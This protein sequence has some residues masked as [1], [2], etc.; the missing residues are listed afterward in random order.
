M[1]SF[2]YIEFDSTYRDRNCYPCPGEFTTHVSCA[3]QDYNGHTARDYVSGEYPSKSWYQVPYAGA[4]PRNFVNVDLTGTDGERLFNEEAMKISRNINGK[5]YSSLWPVEWMEGTRGT[6][7]SSSS[8]SAT[9]PGTGVAGAAFEAPCESTN[10]SDAVIRNQNILMP[11]NF[12]GG[13]SSA[14]Q[15]GPTAIKQGIVNNYFSG[16]TLI[17]F[18]RN[19]VQDMGDGVG[20]SV[21]LGSLGFPYYYQTV[22]FGA[23]TTPLV[24]GRIL[25]QG[26]SVGYVACVL[27]GTHAVVRLGGADPISSKS[28]PPFPAPD[29]FEPGI[30]DDYSNIVS[31][32][33][34]STSYYY[35]GFVETSV[36]T[37]YDA[38]TG[39][40]LLERPFLS[41]GNNAFKPGIGDA[42]HSTDCYLVDFNTDPTGYWGEI[43][44][45]APRL[46]F[47]TGRNVLNYYS[48]VYLQ[49]LTIGQS[50]SA[51]FSIPQAAVTRYNSANRVLY[52]ANPGFQV[53][54]PS[55]RGIPVMSVYTVVFLR[56]PI[57]ANMPAG[58]TV[59]WTGFP[60][61]HLH[62]IAVAAPKGAM[63]IV[64]QGSEDPCNPISSETSLLNIRSGTTADFI[65]TPP[66]VDSEAYDHWTQVTKSAE[67][68]GDPLE[69]GLETVR[70]PTQP[71]VSMAGFVGSYTIA[72]RGKKPLPLDKSIIPYAPFIGD[73]SPLT[74]SFMIRHSGIYELE[75][76]DAGRGYSTTSRGRPLM[77]LLS[78]PDEFEP[79]YKGMG[80][81]P[82]SF[83]KG[84]NKVYTFLNICFVDVIAVTSTGGLL[85]L[86]INTPGSGYRQ[87]SIVTIVDGEGGTFPDEVPLSS[88]GYK[89][90]DG[91]WK[92]SISDS[93]DPVSA[94]GKGNGCAGTARITATYQSIGVFGGSASQSVA[95]VPNMGDSVYIPTYGWGLPK[96]QR[97]IYNSAPDFGHFKIQFSSHE[98]SRNPGYLVTKSSL[99]RTIQNCKGDST[100]YP[101]TGWRVISQA[102][103]STNSQCLISENLKRNQYAAPGCFLSGKWLYPPTPSLQG[104]NE[105]LWMGIERGYDMGSFQGAYACS[106]SDYVANK[107]AWSNPSSFSRD[108]S[109]CLPLAGQFVDHRL[110]PPILL[111]VSCL[112]T[113]NDLEILTFTM[114]SDVPLNYTGSTV[115]QN[116]M[117]CYEVTLVSLILP[118]IPLDTTI[119]GLIAFYPYVYVELSNVSAPS[120]GNK[121]VLYSNNPHAVRA[122]FRCAITNTPT[123]ETSAFI[124]I[125][126]NGAVQT[127]KFK[128]NDNL[129]FRVFFS[130]GK[131]FQTES[132]DSVTPLVPD[133]FVQVSAQFGIRRMV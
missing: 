65:C 64:F 55:D 26:S 31:A 22:S 29:A 125:S 13:T 98:D 92:K 130:D 7:Q 41:G 52:L 103:R 14:P 1:S 60:P 109:C 34:V 48:G 82:E 99:P 113:G 3:N 80:P 102:F 121:G 35:C 42:A 76:L 87:G 78:A 24:E 123:P 124:K 107:F 59:H 9:V 23:L 43:E 73:P 67:E 120:S 91:F 62:R 27:S 15:L 44:R 116:Q 75:I 117:V 68:T 25:Q 18:T 66:W 108:P 132:K 12:S 81:V 4:D 97:T 56:M 133:P 72:V 94:R 39:I 69:T 93:R 89:K 126:G 101:E 8:V 118:N 47:P 112:A 46:F 90:I 105:V 2:R 37:G 58:T 129:H 45:G 106:H 61:T 96:D 127:I 128:P 38:S 17:R 16:A 86:Q 28:Y 10:W 95:G 71:P 70:D 114:D 33:A 51:K 79:P 83:G 100:T 74:M 20:S 54:T 49:N 122:L 30:T 88:H 115:S 85:Q 63:S 36:I 77:A 57:E 110:P 40:V 6:Y 84:K 11:E 19:P 131:V 111:P 5:A 32:N 104:T 53:A 119:G 50:Q 21:P